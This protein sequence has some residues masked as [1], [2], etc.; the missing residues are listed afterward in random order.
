MDAW[1][2]PGGPFRL[3][4]NNTDVTAPGAFNWQ[5]RGL[6]QDPICAPGLTPAPCTT[7]PLCAN[8]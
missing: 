5:F 6:V 2:I 1:I 7:T 8:P 4:V 3:P